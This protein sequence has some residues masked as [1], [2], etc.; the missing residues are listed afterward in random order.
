MT[1]TP[2]PSASRLPPA[3]HFVRTRVLPPA[4]GFVAFLL[5]WSAIIVVGDLQ[6]ITLPTPGQVWER[7]L[8]AWAD[9][10]MLP[11][12]VA[13]LTEILLGFTFGAVAGLL[14]GYVIARSKLANRIVSPY[15]VA[16]QA[17]PILALAPLI[18]IWFPGLRGDVLIVAV[19]VYFPI[20]VSASVAIRSVDRRLIEMARSFRVTRRQR[21]L[22]VEL[23]AALPGILGGLRIGVTLAVVGAIVSEWSGADKGLG[24]LINIAR[25]AMSDTPLVFAA[26]LMIALLGIALY[27]IVVLVERWFTY[28]TG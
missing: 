4:L 11:H 20:A 24:V 9:G 28:P 22:L 13:T 1:A 5:A 26:L 16:S 14:T 10:I 23:P 12:V 6:T 2:N 3:M 27:S 25:G 7:F 15:L 17:V 19:I 8:Q 18:A 21:L